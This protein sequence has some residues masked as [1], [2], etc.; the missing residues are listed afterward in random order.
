MKQ[1]G[2]YPI[3]PAAWSRHIKVIWLSA[4]HTNLLIFRFGTFESVHINIRSAD[5]LSL[6]KGDLL[7]WCDWES[8]RK[9]FPWIRNFRSD[10]VLA[11]FSSRA[12]F[13]YLMGVHNVQSSTFSQQ[14]QT[15]EPW[16]PRRRLWA[17]SAA[18]T[19]W[20]AREKN[21]IYGHFPNTGEFTTT[22]HR[23][24]SKIR[25]SDP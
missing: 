18:T 22:K 23:R 2:G 3:I 6:L 14:R 19:A 5:L 9:K 1:L 13:W 7:V 15:A 8:T 16:L 24:K 11:E 20:K 4:V 25:S 10:D 17:G 12:E 21:K